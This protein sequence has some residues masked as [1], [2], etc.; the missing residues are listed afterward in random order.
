MKAEKKLLFV[1]F[2][3]ALFFWVM[4]TVFDF[5]FFYEES[6][7][8][9]LILDV[10]AHEL[11]IRLVG[12][13]C[14][15]G[16]GVLILILMA[17]HR[18]TEELLVESEEQ[19]R[20]SVGNAFDGINTCE[21]D[22]ATGKRRL[23][24]CNE[25]YVEMS[26]YSREEL[27]NAE[28]LDDLA[29]HHRKAEE[30]AN[31][32][33][34]MVSGMPLSGTAS[35][36]RPDDKENI[37]EF[38][39]VPFKRGDKYQ[40]VGIDR[41]I[42]ERKRAEDALRE[43]EERFR[44][45]FEESP[46]GVELYD[47]AGR[48]VT[49]NEAWWEIFGVQDPVEAKGFELFEDPNVPDQVKEKIR[50]GETVKYETAF[51][52]AKVKESG[53]YR[54]SKSGI[55]FIYVIITPLKPRGEDSISGYLVKVQ[56]ITDRK[57]AEVALQ[58]RTYD[59]GERVKEL[60]CLYGASSLMAA[61]DRSTDAVMKGIAALIPP[62]WQYPE[63]TCARISLEGRQFRTDNF[64][65]TAW[66]QTADITISGEKVGSVE[67]YYLEEKPAIDEGPFFKEERDL[68]DALATEIGRFT[69]RKRTEEAAGRAQQQL[70]ELQRHETEFVEAELAKTREEL[71]R[72]TRLA[73]IGQMSA[74]IAHDLRN[75]LGAIHNAA[76][77][78]KNYVVKGQPEVVDFLQIIDQEVN[79]AD[80][81]ITNLL[82]MTRAKE[83]TKGAVDLGQIVR[84]VFE[85]TKGTEAVRFRVSLAPDPFVV[86]AD[87]DQLRQVTANILNN[88]VWAMKGEGEVLVE[89][90]RDADCDAIV[91]RDNGRGVAPE[92]RE[93]LFEPL[94]TSRSSGTGLGLTICRE[95]IERHGGTIDLEDQKGRGAAFR[96]RLPRK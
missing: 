12:V 58:Q 18:R 50:K 70:L 4:D 54:T 71:V 15:L 42:S 39:A 43:S 95:I 91:F 74:S 28:N 52:F 96:I 77:Y 92:F 51:D 72:K 69:E 84:E 65:E 33:D 9:L 82:Q 13:G 35:W 49:A 11:Y 53:L 66:K 23:I 89:A 17:R 64:N 30:A 60:N 5:Y 79:A 83:P 85:A 1:S 7:L 46:I 24:F 55:I 47:S 81:I 22:P 57:R 94:V 63:I 16:Y 32:Y 31:R 61:S 93:K 38:V 14:I 20:L 73:T 26:G 21:Y 19:F 88:A 56:D 45:I 48:L 40:I 62:S 29:I 76:Y 36:K 2:V 6:F 67:V 44:T 78:L 86:K 3:L 41:D 27:A 59:L 87:S 90:T 8:G 68:I 75:P 10:P 25:R 80:R 34:C 37:Y